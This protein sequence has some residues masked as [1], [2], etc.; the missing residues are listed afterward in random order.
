MK[1]ILF[2]I[3]LLAMFH[4]VLLAQITGRIDLRVEDFTYTKQDGYD[5]IKAKGCHEVTGKVG[6]PDLPVFVRTFVVPLDVSV[7]DVDVVVTGSTELR[8]N[9]IP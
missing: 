9:V 5:V 8:D 2:A 7:T 4:P 1:R 6:A 3:Y